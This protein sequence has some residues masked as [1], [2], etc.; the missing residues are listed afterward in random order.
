MFCEIIPSN[1]NLFL[2][3]F[4]FFNFVFKIK[5]FKKDDGYEDIL[6]HVF[7]KCLALY[8]TLVYTKKVQ[9]I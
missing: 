9:E 2:S 6:G 1:I 3:R 7:F 8:I 5:C 4:C